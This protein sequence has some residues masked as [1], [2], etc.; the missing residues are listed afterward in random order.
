MFRMIQWAARGLVLVAAGLAIAAPARAQGG[1]KVG[2]LTCNVAG[3]WGLVLASW[4]PVSCTFAGAYG[5]ENYTGTIS[6]FGVDIGFTRGAV[7]IWA[8]VAPT[9]VLA[10]GSLTGT[11][12]GGTASASLG[13]GMG[14]NAL[15]GG[16]TNSVALQPLSFE[17][18]R[19]IDVAGGIGALTL[20]WRR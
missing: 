5:Y 20:T 19:G 11:Y 18:V 14:A 2:T 13:V 17:G 7:M 16:S 15:I 6:K 10:P 4:R 9:A 8:V 3:G 1:V 12:V